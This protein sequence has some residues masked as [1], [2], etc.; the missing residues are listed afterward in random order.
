M[1]QRKKMSPKANKKQFTNTAKFTS[2]KNIPKIV[3]RGGYRL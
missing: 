2:V 3:M 1:K